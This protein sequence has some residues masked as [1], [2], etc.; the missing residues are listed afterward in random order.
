MERAGAGKKKMAVEMSGGG[1]GGDGGVWL[2]R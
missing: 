1:V 2:D